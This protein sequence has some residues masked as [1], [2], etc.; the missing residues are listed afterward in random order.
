[1][2]IGVGLNGHS[3]AVRRVKATSAGSGDRVFKFWHKREAAC[4]RKKGDNGV[5]ISHLLLPASNAKDG[6]HGSV[7]EV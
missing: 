7:E 3:I 5:I 2:Q 6:I 4:C 1:M